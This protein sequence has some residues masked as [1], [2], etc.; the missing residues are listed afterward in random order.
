MKLKSNAD[1]AGLYKYLVPFLKLLVKN[2]DKICRNYLLAILEQEKR[3]LNHVQKII[4]CILGPPG[5][6]GKRGRRGE[7]G[8]SLFQLLL[9]INVWVRFLH[10]F[11][12]I[13]DYIVLLE[14]GHKRV[15][16]FKSSLLNLELFF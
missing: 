10:L 2:S 7:S 4:L 1:N 3:M 15:S 6:R 14:V 8:K 5:K 11:L 9:V 12:L 16:V 13:N